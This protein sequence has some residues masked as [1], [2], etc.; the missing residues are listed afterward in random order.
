MPENFDMIGVVQFVIYA[1]FFGFGLLTFISM[2][3]S[4]KS[5]KIKEINVWHTK[6]GSW[7]VCAAAALHLSVFFIIEEAHFIK[8]FLAYPMN[9]F[10]MGSCLLIQI[11]WIKKVRQ[12]KIVVLFFALDMLV[13][14]T[15]GM[16]VNV[17]ITHHRDGIW[18]FTKASYMNRVLIE[19]G[20]HLLIYL[21]AIS[22]LYMVF[23]KD[24]N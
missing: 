20:L 24:K 12:K 11:L 6:M 21:V 19:Y 22:I 4:I 16:I 5:K 23:V 14:S 10:F 17:V 18:L 3:L 8:S 13:Y 2:L 1:M 9:A 15:L 7:I